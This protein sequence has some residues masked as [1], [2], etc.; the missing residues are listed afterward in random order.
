MK[1]TL[2]RKAH[3]NGFNTIRFIAT[4]PTTLHNRITSRL[5]LSIISQFSLP[6]DLAFR[7]TRDFKKE[8]WKEKDE[9]QNQ[10]EKKTKTRSE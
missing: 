10:Q 3:K 9:S 7:D 1:I 4:P 5:A 2:S 8:E 6:L